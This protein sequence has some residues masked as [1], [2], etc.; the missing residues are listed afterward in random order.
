MNTIT[1]ISYVALAVIILLL[2]M[3]N[4]T[5]YHEVS[6][7]VE[8]MRRTF[9]YERQRDKCQECKDYNQCNEPQ[10]IILANSE[11]KY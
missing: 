8:A 6:M 1:I 7:K 2:I 9:E 5:R 4:I 10:K 11:R 3:Y